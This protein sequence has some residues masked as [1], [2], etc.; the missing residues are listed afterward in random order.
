M[1]IDDFKIE[2]Y[3][4]KYEFAAKYLLS[5]SDCD[6]YALKEVLTV[7]SEEELSQ[8]ENQRLGYTETKGAPVLREAI[9]KHYQNI[10]TDNLLVMSPGEANFCLMNVLLQKGDE[11]I[12][13]APMYQ[14]LYQVAES[15]GCTIT[16]WKPENDRD[17]YYDPARL[18]ALVNE[19]TKLIIVNF[20]HNPT[21]YLPGASDWAEIIHIARA[22]NIFLF[23]DEM[24]RSLAAN[25]LNV[26][27]PACELYEN[28]ISL[29][30]MSKSFGLAGLRIGWLATRNTVVLQK[31]EAF[32]DYLTICNSGP[33]EILSMIALNHHQLFIDRN[34]E[35]IRANT[36]LFAAFQ[37][38]NSDLLDFYPPKAG[39][40]AF[41]KLKTNVTAMQ[42]A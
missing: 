27:Q 34:N 32:K 38:R 7:A 18:K 8:W 24:Y 21:G 39:S 23:S 20:P 30:G 5:S 13:M 29:W 36:A 42:Y 16:F 37:K 25:P 40:T 15:I 1:Q 10:G 6:G 19:K 28:G 14:S 22:G 35:K 4:A 12:C 11:V 17:W 9:S 3:F 2:R 41:V 26:L 31:I 33:A